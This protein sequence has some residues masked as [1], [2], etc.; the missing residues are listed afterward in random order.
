MRRFLLALTAVMIFAG[1]SFA[2]V[3]NVGILTQLNTTKDAFKNFMDGA[4]TS[5]LWTRYD[6]GTFDSSN[7]RTM[8][9]FYDSLLA[10]IMGLDRGEIE[11]I[12]LPEAVGKYILWKRP[13]YFV[14]A[15]SIS[16]PV[17]FAMGFRKNDGEELMQKFNGAIKSMKEDGTLSALKE[18][19]ITN[20]DVPSQL[21]SFTKFDGA[22]TIWAAVTGDL[23]PVDYVDESGNPSGFNTALLAEIGRRL[24][25]NIEILYVNSGAR[26]SALASKRADVVFCFRVYSWDGIQPDLPD[27]VITSGSYFDWT[28]YF[29]I[30]KK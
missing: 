19:Y 13:A 26:A 29:H 23:P 24:E 25:I 7:N 10:M 15:E 2:G 17:F 1:V 14:A 12:A 18:K 16:R 8:F 22:Q 30:R 20:F 27:G 6:S 21:V 28:K 9:T 11:E 5:G 4:L 3:L